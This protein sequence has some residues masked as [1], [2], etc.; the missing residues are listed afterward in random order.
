MNTTNL[1]NA[2]SAHDEDV[3]TPSSYDRA[4]IATAAMQGMLAN[5]E[6]KGSPVGFVTDKALRY[7]DSLLEKLQQKR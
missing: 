6:Y 3:L 7:A 2:T 1:E 4:V 5:G